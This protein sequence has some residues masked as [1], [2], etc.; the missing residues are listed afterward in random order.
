MGGVSEASAAVSRSS[1][2]AYSYGGKSYENQAQVQH[3]SDYSSGS[4][5]MDAGTRVKRTEFL[6]PNT[7]MKLKGN[8]YRFGQL[9]GS[10]SYHTVSA[11]DMHMPTLV[12]KSC[13]FGGYTSRGTTGAVDG[14]VWKYWN[15]PTTGTLYGG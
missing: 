14:G 9:C 6:P 13:G 10:S 7:A 15:T 5:A 2:G 8:L 12:S 11:I 3:K 1:M 4:L